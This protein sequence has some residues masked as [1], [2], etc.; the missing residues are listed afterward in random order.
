MTS[1]D[2]YDLIIMMACRLSKDKA[3][4]GNSHILVV[5][6]RDLPQQVVGSN[7][8]KVINGDRKDV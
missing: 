3:I 4:T 5:I 8:R 1:A 6:M 7:S 2:Y